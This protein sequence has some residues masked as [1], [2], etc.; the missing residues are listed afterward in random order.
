MCCALYSVF[1]H[2]ENRIRAA[3]VCLGGTQGWM[4]LENFENG[5]TF[6]RPVQ[7]RPYQ[8]RSLQLSNYLRIYIQ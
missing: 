3:V 5:T 2:D 1:L 4:S 7:A 8:Q 6:A